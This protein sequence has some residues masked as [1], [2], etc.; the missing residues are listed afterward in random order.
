MADFKYVSY[1]VASLLD[2]IKRGEIGLPEI[3]RPFV[4][5]NTNR[6]LTFLRYLI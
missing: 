3:Q 1:N 6:S 5:S 2:R 4:W